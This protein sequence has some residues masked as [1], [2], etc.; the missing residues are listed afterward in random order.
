MELQKD[1]PSPDVNGSPGQSGNATNGN[2]NGGQGPKSQPSMY[3]TTP[4]AFQFKSKT[5]LSKKHW[6]YWAIP[7]SATPPGS[8][9]AASA[10]FSA[11]SNRK[12]Q[13]SN[14][15]SPVA[16]TLSYALLLSPRAKKHH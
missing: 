9:S 4:P 10:F 7:S 14:G 16:H 6:L 5:R 11:G 2:V 13:A 3:D 8:W 12:R 1:G 15:V